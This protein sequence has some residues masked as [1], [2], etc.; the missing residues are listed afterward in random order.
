MIR[1]NIKDVM[2]TTDIIVGFPGETEKDFEETVDI[3]KRVRFDIAYINKYSPRSGTVSYEMPDDVSAEEKKKREIFLNAV[4]EETALENNRKYIG[5]EVEIL[6]EK[7]DGEN[8]FGKTRSFKDIKI[9]KTDKDSNRT[10][11]GKFVKAKITRVTPWA[12]EGETTT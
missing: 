10:L 11:I 8:Y 7:D 4:L 6:I 5:T 9:I 3:M 2:L 1:E 12:L